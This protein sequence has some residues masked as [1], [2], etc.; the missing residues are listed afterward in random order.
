MV[1]FPLL[2]MGG[3]ACPSLCGRWLFPRDLKGMGRK[4]HYQEEKGRKQHHPKVR[5]A[6]GF[7]VGLGVGSTCFKMCALIDACCF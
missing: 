4:H 3:C 1:L 7:G 6:V 5:L 2:L